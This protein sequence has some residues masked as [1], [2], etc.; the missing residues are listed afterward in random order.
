MTNN[1]NPIFQDN[2]AYKGKINEILISHKLPTIIPGSL[3]A[4]KKAKL[5]EFKRKVAHQNRIS[6][7]EIKLAEQ[8]NSDFESLPQIQVSFNSGHSTKK[9][10]LIDLEDTFENKPTITSKKKLEKLSKTNKR[11][12]IKKVRINK[13]NTSLALGLATMMIIGGVTFNN[14]SNAKIDST[15]KVANAAEVAKKTELQQKMEA[16]SE[17]IKNSNNGQFIDP[18][19]DS[20]KDGLTNYEEF[21]IGSNP[22]SAFSCNERINDSENLLNLINPSTCRGINLEDPND[23]KTFGDIVNLP[24]LQTQ[25]GEKKATVE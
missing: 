15:D 21:V 9:M 17:W 18:N 25:I 22:F 13:K 14:L 1:F 12:I 2:V 10:S 11:S 8:L 5:E 7:Q 4:V 19:I 20:D 24:L 3:T 23:V 6:S 16:Y